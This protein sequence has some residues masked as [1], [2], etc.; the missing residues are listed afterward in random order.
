MGESK[1]QALVIKEDWL[2]ANVPFVSF[3]CDNDALYSMRFLTAGGG[4]AF[5]Y[6]LD[7]F[8]DN[9]HYFAAS[10]THPEDQDIVDSHAEQAVAGGA[11]VVSRYRLVQAD[12]TP[13]PV[14]L[15]SQAVLGEGGEIFGLA[16]CSVDLRPIPELDGP[17]ALLSELRKP[18]RR[19]NPTTRPKEVGAQWAAS[20]LPLLTFFTENDAA[21][22]VRH[23]GGSLEEL[24]GYSAE[25]FLSGKYQPASTVLPE[26]QDIADAYIEAAAAKVGQQSCGRLRLL[27]SDGEAFPVLILGRGAQPEGA[28]EVGVA[29]GV[30]D[31]R[32]V[33]ALQGKFGL[34]G[35]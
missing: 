21:Y 13:V 33:P 32:H 14:L 24:A 34:L 19:R 10:T 11:P 15:V 6:K 12:G 28:A 3:I 29:G 17:P 7:D 2:L 1:P 22:T 26:D 20:Q 4:E 23:I 25:E 5:G 18:Q 31:I 35:K 16:G 30:L 8:V 27:D 9:K